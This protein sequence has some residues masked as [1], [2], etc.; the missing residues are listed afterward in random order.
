MSAKSILHVMT[1]PSS[2]ETAAEYNRWYE[3]VHMPEVL[4]LDGFVSA[5]RYG[6]TK[7]GDPYVA[8]YEI[9]GDAKAA[10]KRLNTAMGDGTVALSDTIQMDPP[11]QMHVFELI[12]E[13]AD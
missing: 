12:K 3:D 11:P 6:P 10:V 2:P 7:D 5:R 9:E 8:V 4:A 13:I 1:R